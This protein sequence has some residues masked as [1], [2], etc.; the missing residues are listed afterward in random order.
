MRKPL[1]PVVLLIVGSLP[2]GPPPA[3]ATTTHG[4]IL[5]GVNGGLGALGQITISNISPTLPMRFRVALGYASMNP[6]KAEDA[7]HVFINDNN[8]GTPEKH[9]HT[10]DL[11]LD[12]V[13]PLS[14]K[15]A[16]Q[17][18]GYVGPRYGMFDAHFRYVGDN[19]EFDVTSHQWGLGAGLDWT[20]DIDPRFALSFSGGAEFFGKA[21]LHGHDATYSPD[22]ENVNPRKEYEYRDADEAINQPTLEA[23][24]MGGLVYRFGR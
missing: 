16:R 14:M 13:F 2:F 6:G 21:N 11:G 20:A 4:S 3:S 18:D 17:L 19:E 7:R 22:N 5:M 23:K 8:G 12:V 24:L 15:G 1:I 9:G 10:W